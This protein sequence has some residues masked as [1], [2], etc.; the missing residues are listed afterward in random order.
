VGLACA[1]LL[2]S[3]LGCHQGDILG[4]EPM[5]D[6]SVDTIMCL[7]ITKWIHINHG[8]EGLRLLFQRLY[9]ALSLGGLLLLEPQPWKSYKQA[10]KKQVT[11]QLSACM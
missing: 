7:S 8:D 1:D 4:G 6:G 5:E 9:N 2:L 11:S 3:M 10:L